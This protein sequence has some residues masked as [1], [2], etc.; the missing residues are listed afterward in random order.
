MA[1]RKSDGTHSEE[2]LERTLTDMG[3]LLRRHAAVEQPDPAFVARLRARLAAT[4]AASSAPRDERPSLPVS[5]SRRPRRARAL[6][7]IAAIAALVLGSLGALVV[8]EHRSPAGH[9]PSLS[10][11]PPQPGLADL[12][13]GFPSPAVARAAGPPDPTAGINAVH[14]GRPYAGRVRLSTAALPARPFRL[15][16]FRLDA[17]IAASPARVAT[18]ARRLGVRASIYRARRGG[19][20]WLVAR[21]GGGS[22]A[23][24]VHSLA[25]SLATGDV[26]YHD[27][28]YPRLMR[29]PR[30]TWIDNAAAVAAARAWLTGLGW[31]G[32]RMPLGA[33]EHSGLPGGIRELEFGWIGVGS[34]ALDAAT[35][36]VTPHGR[37]V[38]ADLWPP[39]ES[40][41]PIASRSLTA[42]W[43]A[44]RGGLV[45]LAVEGVP[46][47]TRAPGD[48]RMRTV[49][50][51]HVL[52]TGIDH[53]LY[54]VPTY[55][56]SG[57]AVLRG[58]HGA[59]I[60]YALA[61]AGQAG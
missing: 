15:E 56:F 46:P 16:A 5:V 61:P 54:L 14:A 49:T 29:S 11:R 3:P 18:L 13:Q 51:T 21:D 48:G 23:R 28:S 36:W 26:V 42:A 6:V 17:S 30:E 45:P 2:A 34:A 25:V 41:R 59:R 58:I 4:S 1:T 40:A 37:V 10:W 35:L 31:P 12:M 57:T 44:V 22:S 27:A 38:E 9:T 33:I 52:T 55:H 60:C 8:L 50:I 43:T 7:A 32:S 53:R 24:P 39:L 20:T 19:A 47:N